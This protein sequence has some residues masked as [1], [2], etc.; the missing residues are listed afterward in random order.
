MNR[1]CV[2]ESTGQL[3]RTKACNGQ[4]DSRKARQSG[5]KKIR[6]TLTFWLLLHEVNG[7]K[8]TGLL[9]RHF[10]C[11]NE[12]VRFHKLRNSYFVLVSPSG[13]C[14]LDS[15]ACHAATVT[16]C[17]THNCARCGNSNSV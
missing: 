12:Y 9:S 1:R 11:A 10:A 3:S 14:V 8:V 16:S 2:T 15:Y 4:T 7:T 17:L 6:Y 13:C 5:K